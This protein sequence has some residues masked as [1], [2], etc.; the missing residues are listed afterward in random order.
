MCHF[1]FGLEVW[2]VVRLMVMVVVGREHA[3]R[4]VQDTRP[5]CYV[6]EECLIYDAYGRFLCLVLTLLWYV[7]HVCFVIREN[8]PAVGRVRE[9]VMYVLFPV[10]LCGMDLELKNIDLIPFFYV[11]G[12]QGVPGICI[13]I[14]N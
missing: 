11:V 6:E 13:Y 8:A 9:V 4:G 14:F 10:E 5:I 12:G 3:R 1:D 2:S 7:V